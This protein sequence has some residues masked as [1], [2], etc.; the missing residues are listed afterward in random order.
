VHEFY[1]FVRLGCNIL[2]PEC[3]QGNGC[4]SLARN[5]QN[6]FFPAFVSE[7][8]AVQEND[9]AC[10]FPAF[11]H[12]TAARACIERVKKWQQKHPSNLRE[13]AQL[14]KCSIHK[15]EDL[16]S[17]PRTHRKGQAWSCGLVIPA[18]G[19]QRQSLDLGVSQPHLIAQIQVQ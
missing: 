13:T 5:D 3:L 9:L 7:N 16:S 14:V 11:R 1:I 12:G 4:T 2:N 19:R 6:G 15:L 10:G 18:S 17:I 8:F